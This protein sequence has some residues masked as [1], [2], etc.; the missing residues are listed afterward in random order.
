MDSNKLSNALESAPN[1]VVRISTARDPKTGNAIDKIR[2]RN[3]VDGTGAWAK[4][5]HMRPLRQERPLTT[6]SLRQCFCAAA[7]VS[8][9]CGT[10]ALVAPIAAAYPNGA[11][12]ERR[13][14]PK[15]TMSC[16]RSLRGAL[17]IRT[18]RFIVGSFLEDAR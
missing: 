7:S 11:L 16:A 8:N 1:D 10:D 12:M 15:L 2:S 4:Q 17:L 3:Q 18:R 9:S 13:V 6:W 14:I 5:P